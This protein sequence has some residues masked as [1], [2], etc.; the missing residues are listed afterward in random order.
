MTNFGEYNSRRFEAHNEYK[1]ER[2]RIAED[3]FREQLENLK[4]AD[5]SVPKGELQKRRY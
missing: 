1:K 4:T 3:N 2:A 5:L